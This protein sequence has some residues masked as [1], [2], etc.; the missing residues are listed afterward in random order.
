MMFTMFDLFTGVITGAC[1]DHSIRLRP[2]L[3]FQEHHAD[4]FLDRFREV[5]REIK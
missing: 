3:T 1:G 2:S 5:L 4:I